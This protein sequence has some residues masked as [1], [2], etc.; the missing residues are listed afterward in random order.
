MS[1]GY[2]LLI[3]HKANDQVWEL[4]RIATKASYETHLWSTPGKFEF[5]YQNALDPSLFLALSPG[6]NVTFRAPDMQG[7]PQNIFSGYVFTKK[8]TRYGE[9]TVT[10]Y[11]QLRYLK[12]N[13][14]LD[15]SGMRVDQV[16]QLIAGKYGL[17]IGSLAE[18]A[19]KLG[20]QRYD[21]RCLY[22]MIEDALE[23]TNVG[24]SPK[25]NTAFASF[26]VFYDSFGKLYLTE[27]HELTSPVVIGSQS[28][29]TDYTF[30][31]DIDA[32]TYNSVKVIVPNK[33]TGHADVYE[34]KD[35]TPAKVNNGPTMPQWGNLQYYTVVD[36]NATPAQA[37]QHAKDLLSYYDRQLNTITISTLGVVGVRAGTT[38]WI[39][40]PS[41][42]EQGHLNQQAM[43]M[44]RV[45]H[46][47]ED[48]SHEMELE[49]R[50]IR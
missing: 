36:G 43:Q 20:A 23:Q 29:L 41:L 30:T 17:H 25:T 50:V 26:Y 5:T 16:I 27:C 9:V 47:W 28:L 10:A 49:M 12:A 11:D 42:T 24:L 32:D 13:D 46:T 38:M 48:S 14:T 45:S 2:S 31:E 4:S 3:H 34:A 8:T 40:L 7:T 6:D 1:V 39:N 18:P 19:W 22:E 44:S 35:A 37:A 15:C 33:A 21:N